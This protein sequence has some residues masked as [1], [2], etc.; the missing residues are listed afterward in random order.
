MDA[1]MCELWHL[2]GRYRNT[3]DLTTRPIMMMMM[4]QNAK[5][6]FI[7]QS[8]INQIF[9]SGNSAH[10]TDRGQIYI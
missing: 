5:R 1:V 10:R 6:C 4:M 8:T 2:C 7:N 3:V 9:I